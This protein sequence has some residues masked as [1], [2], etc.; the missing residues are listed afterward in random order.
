MLY[1][2]RGIEEGGFER[3]SSVKSIF[4]G[5][6]NLGKIRTPKTLKGYIY[7]IFQPEACNKS[8]G[9]DKNAC[10]KDYESQCLEHSYV[11][12]AIVLELNAI[13]IP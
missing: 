11:G 7:D 1:D 6:V 2:M 9:F 13:Q 3:D 10:T 5:V 4:G 12:N 8:R